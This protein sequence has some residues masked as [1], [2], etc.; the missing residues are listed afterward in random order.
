MRPDRRPPDTTSKIIVLSGKLK[1]PRQKKGEEKEERQARKRIDALNARVQALAKEKLSAAERS[2]RNADTKLKRIDK[3]I[4]KKEQKLK[5]LSFDISTL[6]NGKRSPAQS[7]FAHSTTVSPG[8]PRARLSGGQHSEHESKRK[9]KRS[10]SPRVSGEEGKAPPE[11]EILGEEENKELLK[12]FADF[13]AQGSL[14]A[15]E[16]YCFCKSGAYGQM[17]QCDN[18]SVSTR[19][20][21]Y[22]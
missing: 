11:E 18:R 8:L 2:F 16:I 9:R 12:S 17:V 1:K 20:A 19:A 10:E 13:I 6:A 4:E 14:P 22:L 7:L 3:K 5:T 21:L 15:C